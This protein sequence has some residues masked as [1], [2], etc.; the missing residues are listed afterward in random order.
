MVP[1]FDLHH[2]LFR[3]G[4]RMP[5]LQRADRKQKSP[6]RGS[7]HPFVH[8]G[9]LV[10]VTGLLTTVPVGA[11][12]AETKKAWSDTAELSLVATDGNSES[13]TLG[14][15]NIYKRSW[16]GSSIEITAAGIRSE[17]TDVTRTAFGTPTAFVVNEAS[18]TDT[19]AENYIV[20]G[21]F[22]RKITDRFFWYVGGG[23]ERNRF[24]GVNNR[25]TAVGGLGNIW[26]EDE[27][28][29]FRTD[30]ALTVT[31]QED[32]ID[33]PEAS[34]TFLGV[35]F[36]WDYLNRWSKTT[37]YENV[38]VIDGNLDETDDIRATMVHA[39][40]VSMSNR[41]ALKVSLKILF[42]NEPSFEN[43]ALFDVPGGASLGT[44]PVQLDEVDT[45]L[46][47]SLVV[48]F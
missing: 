41:L 19:T 34:D 22:D 25:Y 38:F 14:F 20:A 31:D 36:S 39:V 26:F 48:N 18:D 10:A 45:Q 28:L 6:M 29:K 32:V 30:Y 4:T 40:S 9:L 2:E 46:A 7:R 8:V 24:S 23:W 12:T 42:D 3:G 27:D 1:V 11:E 5:V 47:V 35:R 43:V 17:S 37:V 13:Q 33:N 44:V 16:D 21:R 15:K